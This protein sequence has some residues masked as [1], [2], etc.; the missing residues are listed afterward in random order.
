MNRIATESLQAIGMWSFDFISPTLNTHSHS[1]IK[2]FLKFS[3]EKKKKCSSMSSEKSNGNQKKTKKTINN[4]FDFPNAIRNAST[5]NK[6]CLIEETQSFFLFSSL[7]F[8]PTYIFCLQ[9][10]QKRKR[11]IL[12]LKN[13]EMNLST[14]KWD[15]IYNPSNQ[16]T[17]KKKN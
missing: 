12:I 2:Q 10:N 6:Q 5:F 8:M 9:P 4:T 3:Q 7:F 13:E 17:I 16:N 1:F 14:W 15:I 11:K